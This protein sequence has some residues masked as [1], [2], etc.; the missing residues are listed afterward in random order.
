MA[1]VKY[2]FDKRDLSILKEYEPHFRNASNGYVRGIYSVDI[3]KL[4]PLYRKMGYNISNKNC[5]SCLIGMLKKL[6]EA[7]G[8]IKERSC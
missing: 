3:A 1:K 4:E 8:E 5:G 6:G 2:N 7:Y